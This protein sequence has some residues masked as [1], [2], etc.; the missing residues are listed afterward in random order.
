M[1]H[2]YV[3]LGDKFVGNDYF[4]LVVLLLAQASQ[5]CRI[6]LRLHVLLIAYGMLCV[7]V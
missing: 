3:M 7:F 6:W 2:K 4:C 5:L 1:M